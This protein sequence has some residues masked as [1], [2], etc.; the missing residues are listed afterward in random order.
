MRSKTY[1]E[2][3]LLL[4]D[5]LPVR[6]V[7][8]GPNEASYRRRC[9]RR[10]ICLIN[11]RHK[12]TVLCVYKSSPK[13]CACVGSNCV[14]NSSRTHTHINRMIERKIDAAIQVH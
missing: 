1:V 4:A 11:A 12:K 9:C 6:V 2:N 14:Q 13:L 8:G 10:R 3:C 7:R 5:S